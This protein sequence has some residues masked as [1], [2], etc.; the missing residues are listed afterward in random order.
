MREFLGYDTNQFQA[1]AGT[2][3]ELTPLPIFRLRQV[4]ASATALD[5]QTV[6]VGPG[7]IEVEEKP[8]PTTPGPRK[9]IRKDLLIFVT[10]T[11]VDPAGNHTH[12]EEEM[13]RR[14]ELQSQRK[15]LR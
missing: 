3:M 14:A 6:V 7:T 11:I 4:V 5:G 15:P 10:P 1:Q 8:D 2:A 12:S 13:I 9:T